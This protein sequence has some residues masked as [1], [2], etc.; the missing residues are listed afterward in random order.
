[1]LKHHHRFRD[2]LKHKKVISKLFNNSNDRSKNENSELSVVKV[3][4]FG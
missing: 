2:K 1:M 3:I 4:L